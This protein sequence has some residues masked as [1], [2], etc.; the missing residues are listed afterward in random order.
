M[1]WIRK[2]P[3]SKPIPRTRFP[4]WRYYRFRRMVRNGGAKGDGQFLLDSYGISPTNAP[5]GGALGDMGLASFLDLDPS[6]QHRYLTVFTPE[7]LEY[8]GYTPDQARRIIN[9]LYSRNPNALAR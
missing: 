2:I 9:Y 1:S 7:Y 5:L 6:L 8:A 3:Q 4:H